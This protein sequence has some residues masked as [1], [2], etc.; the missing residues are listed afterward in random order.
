VRI[1]F[2]RKG[3]D[4]GSGGAPSPI[5]GGRPISL[6]IPTSRRSATTYAALGLGEVV[7]LATRGRVSGDHLCHD[8]PMFRDG[9]WHF[10]QCGAAQS[11]LA[12]QGVG[13]GDTF[14]FFGLFADEH[15]GERHHRIYGYMDV[16]SVVPLAGGGIEGVPTD[17]PHLIGEWNANNTLYIGQGATARNA[18]GELRLTQPGGP[19]RQWRVPPWLRACGLSFHGKPQ[20]WQENDTL[21]IVSR[22]QE[23]VADIG[24]DPAASTWLREIKKAIRG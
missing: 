18:S 2:S 9:R 23:F 16:R 22:G 6:P 4:S 20:R 21:E 13:V 15:T 12:N 1:I 3:F 11:H 14:L 7:E 19:L 17:H 5:A 24:D 8:D 10:G